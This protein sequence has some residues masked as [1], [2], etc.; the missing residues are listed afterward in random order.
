MTVFRSGDAPPGWCELEHFDVAVL[1]GDEEIVLPRRSSRERL[2]LADGFCQAF[3]GK[4]SQVLR[5]GQFLDLAPEE[6]GWR[7][8]ANGARAELVRFCGRWGDELGGC[9]LFSVRAGGP[10]VV[11]GDP[12][13]YPRNTSFDSHYHD[14]DEYWLLLDG[15][16][17]VVVGDRHMEAGPGDAIAIGMGHH[18]DF[19]QVARPVRAVYFETTLEGAKRPGHLWNH[20]HGPAHPKPDRI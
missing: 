12:V 17:T 11:K 7:L 15:S 8:R 13:D 6:A 16:G 1:R 3:A 2:L 9:G 5:E 10:E 20:T 19:P 18:H 14:C 4:R